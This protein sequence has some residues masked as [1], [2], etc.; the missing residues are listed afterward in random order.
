MTQK[1]TEVSPSTQF[2]CSTHSSLKIGDPSIPSVSEPKVL[3]ACLSWLCH[4]MSGWEH[5]QSKADALSANTQCHLVSS[6]ITLYCF[7]KICTAVHANT[8]RWRAHNLFLNCMFT[9][10]QGLHTILLRMLPAQSQWTHQKTLINHKRGHDLGQNTKQCVVN[11]IFLETLQN[12]IFILREV[13]ERDLT[14][15]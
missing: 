14:L 10:I 13:N 1:Q 15:P 9:N 8:S 3:A 6:S 7:P 12:I 11:L 4:L 2:C 5:G